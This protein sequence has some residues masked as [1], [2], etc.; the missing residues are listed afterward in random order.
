MSITVNEQSPLFITLTFTDEVGGALIPTT[1][2]WRLDNSTEGTEIVD[3]TAL[4]GP[5]ASMSMVIGDEHHVISDSSHV[6]EGRILGI[7]IN[8]GIAL[9]AHEQ[10]KYHVLNMYGT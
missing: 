10:H 4:P 6:K 5:A 1:V 2:E 8:N 9:E 3:W 7:R